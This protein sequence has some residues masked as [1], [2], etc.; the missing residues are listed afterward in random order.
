MWNSCYQ[1]PFQCS[2]GLW[3]CWYPCQLHRRG[4]GSQ[5]V[6]LEFVSMTWYHG[7]SAKAVLAGHEAWREPCI[8]SQQ[9]CWKFQRDHSSITR[10][11][12]ALPLKSSF[13]SHH[14]L[15][16]PVQLLL[17]QVNRTKNGSPQRSYWFE[18]PFWN[19]S[20]EWPCYV[21]LPSLVSTHCQGCQASE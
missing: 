9:T 16:K 19:P 8:P 18:D 20:W 11:H 17:P 15:W 5:Q 7:Q 3:S 21:Q 6:L 12:D 4:N 13:C 1:G 2:A 10:M 14:F